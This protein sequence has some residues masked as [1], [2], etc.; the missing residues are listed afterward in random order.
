MQVNK[1]VLSKGG[2][3][4]PVATTRI[5]GQQGHRQWKEAVRQIRNAGD[6]HQVVPRGAGNQHTRWITYQGHRQ[7]KEAIRQGCQGQIGSSWGSGV[8]DQ[9]WQLV[10]S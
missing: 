3:G 6:K 7:L 8:S 5:V 2:Q 1:Q 4:Y 9:G 10:G